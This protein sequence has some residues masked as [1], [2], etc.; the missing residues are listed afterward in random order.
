MQGN[1][2]TKLPEEIK[3]LR[4]LKLLNLKFNNFS[5]EEKARIKKLLP[6]TEIK[7]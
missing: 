6:N 5:D 7:F 3:K 2:L 1:D 4:N